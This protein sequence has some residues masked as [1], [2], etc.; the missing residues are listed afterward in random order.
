[1]IRETKEE[2][3]GAPANLFQIGRTCCQNTD[4]YSME[5]FIFR[6]E[7]FCSYLRDSDEAKPYRIEVGEIPY[8]DMWSTDRC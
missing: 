2:V 6:A 8:E 1:M 3:G 4:G 7:N 5:V